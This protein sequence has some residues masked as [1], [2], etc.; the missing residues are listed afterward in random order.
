MHQLMGLRR[1]SM[2]LTA[3]ACRMVGWRRRKLGWV[4]SDEDAETRCPK[5]PVSGAQVHQDINW[6]GL[7]SA[8][9]L[10]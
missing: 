9:K 6:P 8:P 1:L 2:V 10:P 3:G 5:R 4:G 7:T